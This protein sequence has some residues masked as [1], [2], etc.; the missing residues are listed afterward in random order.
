MA[1]SQV[2][3]SGLES[4][5]AHLLYEH[6]QQL[7]HTDSTVLQ[8]K[9][10]LRKRLQPDK[11][12]TQHYKVLSS[13]SLYTKLATSKFLTII[14]SRMFQQIQP[15]S[16][17]AV[18]LPYKIKTGLTTGS[19][20]VSQTHKGHRDRWMSSWNVLSRGMAFHM[21]LGFFLKWQK[22]TCSTII[23]YSIFFFFLFL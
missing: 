2:Q 14:F 12:Y 21:F 17:G 11:N 19:I 16:S 7:W 22:F 3:G 8:C 18:H 1:L 9:L 23:V 15:Q 5:V 6:T 20:Y 13:A 10:K 4:I